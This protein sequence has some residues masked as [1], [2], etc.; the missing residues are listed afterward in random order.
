MLEEEEGEGEEMGGT[1]GR[2]RVE[3]AAVAR[4]WRAVKAQEEMA[5]Q[6]WDKAATAEEGLEEARAQV[7]ACVDAAIR[8]RERVARVRGESDDTVEAARRRGRKETERAMEAATARLQS[9]VQQMWRADDDLAIAQAA[10][11]DAEDL[12]DALDTVALDADDMVAMAREKLC[13]VERRAAW[14]R[15]VAA[16]ERQRREWR[17]A[18]VVPM[19]TAST[20]EPEGGIGGDTAIVEGLVL[21]THLAVEQEEL[22]L[23]EEEHSE[24]VEPTLVLRG[25][26]RARWELLAGKSVLRVH[27]SHRCGGGS[28][29]DDGGDDGSAWRQFDPGG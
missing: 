23:M 2:R 20:G 22:V 17:C 19:E 7:E 3:M 6:A 12:A 1:A 24:G 25:V 26:V 27:R 15:A 28:K 10:L 21:P 5:S 13:D 4:A 14:S 16:V 11:D 9:V 29:I 18:Q 8:A